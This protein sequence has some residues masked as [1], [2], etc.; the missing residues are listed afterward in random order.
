[1]LFHLLKCGILC[2]C[3]YRMQSMQ[4]G[5]GSS[6]FAALQIMDFLSVLTPPFDNSIRMSLFFCCFSHLRLMS[7]NSFCATFI[8]I[9]KFYLC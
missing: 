7:T 5:I 2:E 1:M 4:R 9:Q 6:A 3:F 8:F